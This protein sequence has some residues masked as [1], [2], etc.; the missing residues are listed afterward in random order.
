MAVNYSELWYTGEL[1]RLAR[2]SY[3]ATHVAQKLGITQSALTNGLAR[4][5]VAD[6]TV[7]TMSQLLDLQRESVGKSVKATASSGSDKSLLDEISSGGVSL[8][9]FGTP[10]ERVS[11]EALVRLGSVSAAAAELRLEPR[12]LRAHLHELQRRAAKRGHAPGSD[13][14]KS[15]PQG[16]S[17]KGVSTLYGED[18]AV[19]QQ[20]VKT[21]RDEDDKIAALLD[22]M[23]E[24]SHTWQ[25]LAVPVKKPKGHLDED[26]LAVYPMGD[27][28]LGLHSWA[29]ETGQPFDLAIAERDLFAAVDHLVGLA[30]P[31]KQALIIS[32]GDFFH[33]DSAA[34]TTTAGTRVDVDTRWAK[35]LGVGIRT[36][37]RCIDRALERHGEVRVVCEL[38]NHDFS[39]SMMLALCLQQYY[40][41]DPRVEVDTSPSKYH[42]YRFGLN[43]LGITHGDTCKPVKLAGIMACDKPKDWGET[44]HRYW[45]TG[46][47]HHDRAFE[48]NG[49]LIE[50][51][52]TLAPKDAW[53][54]GQG[55]R[56]GQD[57]KMDLLH[58]E[59]G[60]IQRNTVG[61]AQ[62]QIASK[63][64]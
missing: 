49:V 43:L 41:N 17:V 9:A 42:W 23:S 8:T 6:P 21:K 47:I 46:H 28:H 3:T 30:P 40:E 33:A 45:Y 59:H 34:A 20:W 32:L 5:R 38:G 50:S 14:T 57:M 7:P 4:L 64:K 44:Q 12:Q 51:F 24:I 15:T 29:Q 63:K 11:A 25:G 60:R 10:I 36:M 31:A 61:I 19:R 16:F 48:D 26:L 35:V 55:Y 1:T 39:S 62:V 53:H 52:R 18:G 13:M 56:S 37:R 22:A 27:P 58:K 54:S 2:D